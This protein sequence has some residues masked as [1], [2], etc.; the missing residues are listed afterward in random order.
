[1]VES[2]SFKVE[3]ARV[4]KFDYTQDSGRDVLRKLSEHPQ[5]VIRTYATKNPFSKVIAT[6]YSANNVDLYFNLRK[7]PRPVASMIN[8]AVHECSHLFGYSHGSNSNVGKENSV[9]YKIGVIAQKHVD[10]CD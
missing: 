10:Q 1:M 7:N 5:C 6:T 8:T 3:L 2:T 9:P 4:E